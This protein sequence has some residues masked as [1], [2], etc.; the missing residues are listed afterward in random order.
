MPETIIMLHVNYTSIKK[1]KPP[2]LQIVHKLMEE[3]D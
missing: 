2:Q 1:K 3:T